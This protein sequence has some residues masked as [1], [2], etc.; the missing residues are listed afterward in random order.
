MSIIA[1]L[2]II[3]FLF[4]ISRFVKPTYFVPLLGK[5]SLTSITTF[6]SAKDHIK[7]QSREVYRLFE[8]VDV[9]NNM[10]STAIKR[11]DRGTL[12]VV[13]DELF[14][15]LHHLF[16]FQNNK[17]IDQSWHFNCE[18]FS[19]GLSD[20]GQYIL[21]K[22]KTWPE[23]YILF[24]ILENSLA[25]GD[26]D[27]EMIPYICRKLTNS[28][29]QSNDVKNSELIELHLMTLNSILNH[30]IETLSE[31]K[32][33]SILYY[34]RLNIETLI[35][36]EKLRVYAIDNFIHYGNKALSEHLHAGAKE[37]LYELGRVIHYLSFEEEKLSLE[38][39]NDKIKDVWLAFSS[40]PDHKSDCLKAIVKTYWTLYSQNYN[41]ITDLIKKDFL[42]NDIEHAKIIKVMISIQNPLNKEFND[43]LVSPELI[44]GMAF[45]MAKEFLSEN[46]TTDCTKLSEDS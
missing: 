29:D 35:D 32:F 1:M 41:K 22:H 6:H 40:D 28:I 27:N 33:T 3:P 43:T 37:Y 17:D 10:A 42:Q 34:Y 9:V 31:S 39:Y 30:S 46:E 16:E 38:V 36:N 11:R 26:R 25:M 19:A 4:L 12:K 21:K 44:T 45:S 24:K 13:L 14:N 23:A 15:V 18:Y 5:Y 8:I 20:E 7:L 2:G